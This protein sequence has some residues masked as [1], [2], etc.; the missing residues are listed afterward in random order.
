MV[1]KKRATK[2]PA[3]PKEPKWT[4]AGAIRD[5]K[6]DDPKAKPKQIVDDLNVK[7][8]GKKFTTQ[9]VY[10]ARPKK[11]GAKKLAASKGKVAAVAGNGVATDF[12]KSAL[13]LGLD[14]AISLLQRVKAA[15]E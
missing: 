12:V 6:K 10:Q 7:F 2:K 15:V 13:H 4:K 14:K 11:R 8:P 5:Y 3:A 1:A 9:D